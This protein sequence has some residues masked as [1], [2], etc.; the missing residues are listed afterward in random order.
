MA[1]FITRV[2]LHSATYQDY[3]ELHGFMSQEG[4]STTIRAD[5]GGVYQ[6]PPAEYRLEANCTATQARDK[7]RRAAQK[8]N[9]QFAVLVSE[10]ISA[11]W[12]GL[13]KV[14]ARAA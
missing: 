6:L 8:T 3:V 2:E 1:T 10:Y 12:V 7:A 9:K 14:Q 4:F 11:C 13:G 5:D